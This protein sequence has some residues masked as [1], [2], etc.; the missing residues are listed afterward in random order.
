M[1]VVLQVHVEH[2]SHVQR[3]HRLNVMTTPANAI[4]RIALNNRI[5]QV[6]RQF[7]VGMEDVYLKEEIAHH[8]LLH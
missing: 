7:S 5:A 8:Q 4:R 2:I 1:V 3:K 6:K